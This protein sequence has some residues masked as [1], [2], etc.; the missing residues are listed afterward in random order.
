M[1]ERVYLSLYRTLNSQKALHWRDIGKEICKLYR[2]EF[3]SA[4]TID[5][6]DDF[7][8]RISEYYA[9]INDG[10]PGNMKMP[11]ELNQFLALY[12]EDIQLFKDLKFRVGAIDVSSL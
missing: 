9:L 8:V 12:N 5:D 11:E 1:N 4:S 6:K 7:L 10:C 2:A 3:I